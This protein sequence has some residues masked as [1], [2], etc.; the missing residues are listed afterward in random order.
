MN[1]NNRK[2]GRI[3]R[4]QPSR[5][6]SAVGSKLPL[7]GS[8]SPSTVAFVGKE[9]PFIVSSR[10]FGFTLIELMIILVVVAI[11]VSLAVPN[12]R[13]FIQDARLTSQANRFV[14][15]ISAARTRS[16]NGSVV[17][18]C[19]STTPG[20]CLLPGSPWEGGR[21]MFIDGNNDGT[22]SGSPTDTQFRY[23]EA[24]SST[25][26]QLAD[27]N[28]PMV[29]NQGALTSGGGGTV[30]F[31]LCDERGVTHGRV[32]TINRAGQVR[33]APK[34]TQPASCP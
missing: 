22:W 34:T 2:F 3:S 8:I 24:M 13:T 9:M 18:I 20:T 31:S 28:D 23:T 16:L 32:I 11:L 26:T 17:V 4:K 15:D 14:T 33:V 7:V 19:P 25:N 10:Q 27:T 21:F 30:T 6:R 1:I 29:F 12:M 5:S